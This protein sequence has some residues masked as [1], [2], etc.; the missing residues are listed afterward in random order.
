MT[1]APTTPTVLKPVLQS[2]GAL[3]ALATI[4]M[5]LVNVLMG[6]E[7][8]SFCLSRSALLAQKPAME[9]KMQQLAAQAA[10]ANGGERFNLAAPA[11]VGKVRRGHERAVGGSTPG[12]RVCISGC[13]HLAPQ[14]LAAF[15]KTV[16]VPLSLGLQVGHSCRLA[17]THINSSMPLPA[18]VRVV[19]V[20]FQKLKLA[21]P[22]GA[23][24]LK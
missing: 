3:P 15:L 9:R 1:A 6:M 10:A 24:V 7:A 19:Q 20:L 11:E 4:E 18:A 8:R 2:E 13:V 21:P 23:K 22:P 14:R 5:P 17:R 16:L 12:A